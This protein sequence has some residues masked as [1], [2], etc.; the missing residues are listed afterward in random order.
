MLLPDPASH[1]F[2]HLV[3]LPGARRGLTVRGVEWR[4]RDIRQKFRHC[5]DDCHNLLCAL[6]RYV[7]INFPTS[8]PDWLEPDDIYQSRFSGG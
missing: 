6:G 3:C 7:L 1:E 4:L 8:H 5:T 2:V